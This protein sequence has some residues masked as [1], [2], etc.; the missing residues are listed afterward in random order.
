[1]DFKPGVCPQPVKG[2]H[3][4]DLLKL[5]R[6]CMCTY[7][8]TFFF[9]STFSFFLSSIY[10]PTYISVYSISAYLC[11]FPYLCYLSYSSI[12]YLMVLNI[13]AIIM[14]T[15]CASLCVWLLCS[16]HL[17][18]VNRLCLSKLLFLNDVY[19]QKALI[20]IHKIC[21]NCTS[22]GN[23]EITLFDVNKKITYLL[24]EFLTLQTQIC[25]TASQQIASLRDR[26][27]QVVT[28]A[29]QVC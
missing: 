20:Y 27:L 1:M 3:L 11:L 7:L 5:L 21:D 10:L 28:V 18:F 15:V 29:C 12:S 16:L 9:L 2:G 4:T 13:H 25:N 6:V 8:S 17:Y 23:S 14:L 24:D 26:I 19:L 22:E